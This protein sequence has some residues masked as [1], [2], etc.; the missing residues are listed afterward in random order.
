M[1]YSNTADVSEV[2]T[3]VIVLRKMLRDLKCS[4]I[5][6]VQK[7]FFRLI[8]SAFPRQKSQCGVH[9]RSQPLESEVY[10]SRGGHGWWMKV[11]M[12]PD[13]KRLYNL[14]ILCNILTVWSVAGG[15]LV[16]SKFK[17]ADCWMVRNIQEI[18]SSQDATFK[19]YIKACARDGLDFTFFVFLCFVSQL[20]QALYRLG[21]WE[22]F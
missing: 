19:R 16:T 7:L 13:R 2:R 10:C 18:S 12:Y 22:E 8:F 14:V 4:I 5:T 20:K 9:F 6:S 21:Q 17:V 1:E 11:I 15:P 3:F